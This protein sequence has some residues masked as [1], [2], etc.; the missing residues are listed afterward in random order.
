MPLRGFWWVRIEDGLL[1]RPLLRTLPCP[2]A[3]GSGAIDAA[4]EAVDLAAADTGSATKVDRMEPA[5]GDQLV[6]L[7]PSNGQY[8]GCLLDVE[9]PR[10][11]SFCVVVVHRCLLVFGTVHREKADFPANR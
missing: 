8:L 9:E 10:A 2:V 4:D 1:D 5:F 7:G 3:R 6:R 11:G